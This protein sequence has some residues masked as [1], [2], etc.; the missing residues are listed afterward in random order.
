[1]KKFLLRI[2]LT[3]MGLL[4]AAGPRLSYA[5]DLGRTDLDAVGVSLDHGNMSIMGR[6]TLGTQ[7]VTNV[8]HTVRCTYDFSVLGG[9]KGTL[10]LRGSTFT[11]AS[12]T[13]QPCIVPAGA[14]VTNALIDVITNPTNGSTGATVA[15]STG[16]TAGDLYATALIG[17]LTNSELNAGIPVGT[18]ATSIKM[19][20]DA[21]PSIVIATQPLTAGKFYVIIQYVLSQLL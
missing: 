11:P 21:H 2:L 19:A 16:Q 14:I 10:T 9:A 18:A 7:A 5:I 12:P 15:L 13:L 20:A 4:S 8:V 1:M 3:A 17:N 6:Y